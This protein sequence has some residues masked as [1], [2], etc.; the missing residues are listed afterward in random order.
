MRLALNVPIYLRDAVNLRAAKER[1]TSRHIVM[2]GL[3]AI[4]F[5]INPADMA[6][7]G[8]QPAPKP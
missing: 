5:E 7:D 6:A 2:Q 8:R 4:G 3:Q 1:C